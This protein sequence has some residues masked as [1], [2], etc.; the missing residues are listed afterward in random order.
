MYKCIICAH[1]SDCII[2]LRPLYNT[3]TAEGDLSNMRFYAFKKKKIEENDRSEEGGSGRPRG[4]SRD[5]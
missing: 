5:L 1:N 2:V 3:K 4:I